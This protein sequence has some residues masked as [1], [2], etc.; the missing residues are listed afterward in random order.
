MGP[1]E[2]ENKPVKA[3]MQYM[4]YMQ[5]MQSPKVPPPLLHRALLA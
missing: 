4:Q 3:D 2:H 1:E 5:Y